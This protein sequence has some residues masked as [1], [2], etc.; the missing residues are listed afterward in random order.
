[1]IPLF[2]EQG[3]AMHDQVKERD[4]IRRKREKNREDERNTTPIFFPVS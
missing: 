4:R 3:F 1:V 2:F